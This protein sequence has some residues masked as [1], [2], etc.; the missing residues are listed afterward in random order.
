M[1]PGAIPMYIG[2]RNAAMRD[3]SDGMAAPGN[4]GLGHGTQNLPGLGM[5]PI[6]PMP[7]MQRNPHHSFCVRLVSI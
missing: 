3:S 2:K 5:A 4:T 7:R 1:L 6:A